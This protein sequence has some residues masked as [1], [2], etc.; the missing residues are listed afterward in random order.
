MSPR[1]EDVNARVRG[2]GAHFL[3]DDALAALAQSPDLPALARGLEARGVLSG[4]LPD[5]TAAALELALRRAAAR[6]V[7][8]VRRWLGD[9]DEVV[10]AAIEVED[11][12]SLRAL[13]RGA[14]AGASA[15]ARLTG[16]IPTP[17]LPERLLE[18]LA[19]R[20]RIAEQAALLVAAGHPYGGPLLAAASDGAEPDLFALELVLA[21]TFA[22]RALRGA[23]R[24]GGVLLE[25]VVTR[26][27]L[28]N[29]RAAV[30]LAQRGADEPAGPVFVLGGRLVDRETFERAAAAP[31][32]HTAARML[33]N[34]LGGGSFA[35]LLLRHAGQPDALEDAVEG[36][37]LRW[38]RHRARLDP[39]GPAPLLL[40]FLRLRLQH[41]ALA[42]IVWGVDLGVPPGARMPQPAGSVG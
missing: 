37:M 11:R 18:E 42:R 5:P 20:P 7:M 30:L 41:S 3:G 16:L 29:A 27:D 23:R 35:A 34:A 9:R 1:W 17:E 12:R 40:W 8:V 32:A 14:A 25:Y 13:I 26:I 36:A 39:L 19:S 33:G 38:L 31:D 4:E 22:E 15:E 24:A 21:R 28:E 6:D 10:T 2:L